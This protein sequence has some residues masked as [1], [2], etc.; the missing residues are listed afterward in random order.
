M[1]NANPRVRSRLSERCSE[2]VAAT[3]RRKGRVITAL[4]IV[5]HTL[6]LFSSVHAIM[7]AR[8]AQ[9]AIAW[10]VSLN[11]FPYAAVP[12]YWVFGRRKFAGYVEAFQG[13]SKE[14]S[15]FLQ[16]YRHRLRPHEIVLEERIPDY[17]ALKRLART[18]LVGGNDVELLIDGEAT[19][20]SIVAG[21]G[22][23]RESVLVEFYIVR[24]DGLGRRLQEALIEKV[25]EG[26]RVFFLYD[27]IGSHG[28]TRAYQDE[29]RAA[30]VRPW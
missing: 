28:L 3:W 2:A 29:L 18:P 15:A 21:I 14:I 25:R 24:D 19:F 6:G 7:T 5:A 17:E 1:P 11:T 8:T 26:V 20:D 22:R 16:E 4:V 9:G 12:A 10:A 23:A 30:G 27:E 13:R